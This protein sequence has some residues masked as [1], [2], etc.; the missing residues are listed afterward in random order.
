MLD[1]VMTATIPSTSTAHQVLH[2]VQLCCCIPV[3]LMN[4]S[5]E[6]QGLSATAPQLL[7]IRTL[8]LHLQLNATQY[9][10]SYATKLTVDEEKLD[11]L[12]SVR[13][14]NTVQQ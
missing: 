8:L 7:L 10:L 11:R 1:H 12:N 9:F 6:E 2:I 4:S 3:H 14:H 5:H 13:F